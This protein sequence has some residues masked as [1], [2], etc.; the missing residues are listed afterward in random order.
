MFCFE[1]KNVVERTKN[2]VERTKT[3]ATKSSLKLLN[4]DYSPKRGNRFVI[5]GHLCVRKLCRVHVLLEH[6]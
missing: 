3:K 4:E 1:T 2:V 6:S 5:S